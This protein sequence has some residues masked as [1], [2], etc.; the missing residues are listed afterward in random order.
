MRQEQGARNSSLQASVECLSVSATLVPKPQLM[1]ATNSLTAGFK[2]PEPSVTC[3]CKLHSTG[4]PQTSCWWGQDRVPR[5]L[6]P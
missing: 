2:F 5:A 1:E 3:S 4:Q 6:G